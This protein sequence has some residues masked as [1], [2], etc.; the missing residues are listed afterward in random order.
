[1]LGYC[2]VFSKQYLAPGVANLALACA[3]LK[4]NNYFTEGWNKGL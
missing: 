3:G 4:S 2:G 1:M